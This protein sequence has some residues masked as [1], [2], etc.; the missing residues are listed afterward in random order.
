MEEATAD[1]EA[2]AADSVAELADGWADDA[3][4]AAAPPAQPA[5]TAHMHKART[6]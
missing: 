2:G 1:D 4:G 6:T 5:N 3:V